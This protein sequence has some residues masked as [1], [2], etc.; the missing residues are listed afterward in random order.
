V[1]GIQIRL[2]K[3]I[4]WGEK[5]TGISQRT[6]NKLQILDRKLIFALFTSICAKVSH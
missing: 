5:L 2:N 4:E 1:L 3:S 6:C